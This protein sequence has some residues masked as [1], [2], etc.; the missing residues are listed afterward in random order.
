M[1]KYSNVGAYLSTEREE[2]MPPLR[3]RLQYFLENFY[4]VI[5]WWDSKGVP[6]SK[7]MSIDACLGIDKGDLML[8]PML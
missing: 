7:Y 8:S 5:Y 3:L 6:V 2:L 4:L 1:S